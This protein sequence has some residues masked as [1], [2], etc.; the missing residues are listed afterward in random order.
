M[1]SVDETGQRARVVDQFSRQAPQYAALRGGMHDEAIRRLLAATQVTENDTV[2]DVA[3]G[4]GQLALAFAE[5]ASRVTGIDVTPAMIERA[6]TLQADARVA[7]VRWIVGDAYHLP[8]SAG[9]FSVVACRYA[10]H[11]TLDPAAVAAEMTRVC[12]PGG[13]VALVDVI[14]T[15]EKTAA[16]NGMERLR[17]PSHVRALTLDELIR[18]ATSNGLKDPKCDFYQYE[19]ELETLLKGSSPAPGDEKK[20]R[21]LI[22]QDIDRNELG[23]GVHRNGPEIVVSYPIALV[24]AMRV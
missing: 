1:P 12:A 18:L 11:H 7:S 22:V 14:T 17:D 23:V 3:C 5:V 2:L 24:T 6:Q 9:E 13:R 8:F 20:V 16:F 10:L 21:E 4:T 19:I 15:D